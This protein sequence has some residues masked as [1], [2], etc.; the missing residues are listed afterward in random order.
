[1]HI[2]K[3]ICDN[4]LSILLNIGGKSKHH[5][6]ARKDRQEIGITKVIH[7]VLSTNGK[8]LEIRATIFNMTN[9]EKEIVCLAF[10]DAKLS[11]SCAANI[12]RYVHMKE[13]KSKVIRAMMLILYS[14]T[15]YNLS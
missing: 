2:E 15:C 5:L 1:M 7:L 12:S 4:I 10:V 6:N 9:K 14:T 11:Y 8:D 13:R 3:K